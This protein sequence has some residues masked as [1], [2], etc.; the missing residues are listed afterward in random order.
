[1]SMWPGADDGEVAAHCGA[2][3]PAFDLRAER[4]ELAARFS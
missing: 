1:M 2:T 4:L 3:R